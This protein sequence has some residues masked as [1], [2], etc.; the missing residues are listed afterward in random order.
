MR[1]V[2]LAMLAAC[3]RIGFETPVG[4]V[5]DA[6]LD[7]VIPVDAPPT[8]PVLG[9]HV[10]TELAGA[11]EISATLPA[12]AAGDLIVAAFG[13]DQTDGSTITTIT[14]QLNTSY[15]VL[16]PAD[17]GAN[18]RQYLAYG[19]ATGSGTDLVT[20]SV[21]GMTATYT[22]LRLHEYAHVDRSNPLDVSAMSA[23]LAPAQPDAIL[24]TT[25]DNEV[26]LAFV[27]VNGGT[28]TAAPGWNAVTVGANDL[29]AD[30]IA[31]IAGAQTVS[32]VVD[33]GTWTMI[34]AAFRGD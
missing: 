8:A 28:A 14:D 13:Y 19:F 23:A 6:R 1:A 7:A 4:V 30:R 25:R 20:A 32:A 26:M 2:V 11:T 12:V 3:G 27:I 10:E 29:T 33:L 22:T 9:G 15:T 21:T 24:V 34:C 17:G 31:A 16:G 18:N 5:G